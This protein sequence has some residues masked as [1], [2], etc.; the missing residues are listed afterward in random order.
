MKL[1]IDV[2]HH[3]L[4][5]RTGIVQTS[6]SQFN[7]PVFMPVGTR[8]AI[9]TIA[10]HDYKELG[11]EIVLGNAYHLMLRPGAKTVSDFGGLA[12]FSGW[13][14]LTLTDSGGFQVFSLSP[15]VHDDGVRFRSTYDGSLIELTPEGAVHTQELLGADIQMVLDVCSALP[16]D[17]S[18]LR[19]A[20]IRTHEWAKR[21]KKAHRR[22]GD[23]SLFGIIQGGDSELLRL[24][25]ARR[26]VDLDFDGY[27]IGGLSV[28]ESRQVMIDMLDVLEENNSFPQNQ[29]RYLMGIGDPIGIIEAVLRGIDMFDCVLPTRL[30]R[31]GVLLTWEGKLH[32]R[33]AIHAKSEE[34]I[35]SNCSC[36]VCR[37]YSR[38]FIRHLVA[39]REASAPYLCSLHNLSWM[40]QYMNAIREAIK[41]SDVALVSLRNKIVSAYA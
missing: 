36:K 33:N 22:V 26:T 39:Q 21:A 11:A 1:E 40:F 30:G 6:K 8:G 27:A 17:E 23:Q 14:G 31:H 3:R 19:Q 28:G 20:M 37:N 35:D 4:G 18:T 16:S 10:A 9:R 7:T 25:S 29:P 13:D 34:P 38:G 5:A 12:K 24:E 41:T 2:K 15:K 32:I